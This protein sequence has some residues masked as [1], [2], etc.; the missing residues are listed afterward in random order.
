MPLI[1]PMG[2]DFTYVQ[3]ANHLASRI[4]VGEFEHKLPAER[5]LAEEY[6]VA[7]QT[8]RHAM[9]VLRDRGLIITRQGRGTFV[10]PSARPAGSQ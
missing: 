4:E 7:Y 5:E 1:D 8:L 2:P 6:E 3:V 10:A 9:K